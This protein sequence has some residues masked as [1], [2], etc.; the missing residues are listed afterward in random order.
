MFLI[1]NF[2]NIVV[3]FYL[4]NLLIYSMIIFKFSQTKLED[5]FVKINRESFNF[6]PYLEEILWI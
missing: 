3:K 6:K 2:N 5:N 1:S 4:K